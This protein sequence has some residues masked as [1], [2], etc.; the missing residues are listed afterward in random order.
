MLLPM[1]CIAFC[2]NR[3]SR[4][5]LRRGKVARRPHSG[6]AKR[7]RSKAP[8]TPSEPA[9]RCPPLTGA[10]TPRTRRSYGQEDPD[11]A[12]ETVI[13]RRDHQAAHRNQSGPGRGRGRP[14]DLWLRDLRQPA[15]HLP[16]L[17]FSSPPSS[18]DLD[19]S[20]KREV[21]SSGGRTCYRSPPFRENLI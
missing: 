12:E 8:L 19:A 15:L 10:S 7:L 20:W 9:L 18:F 13:E 3:L 1:S 2:G 21:R 6:Q 11:T 17:R 5:V 4:T 14:S 16:G